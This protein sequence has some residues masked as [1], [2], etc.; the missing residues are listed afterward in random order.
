MGVFEQSAFISFYRHAHHWLWYPPTPAGSPGLHCPD[1]LVR[2]G[3]T[4]VYLSSQPLFH[5]IDMHTTGCGILQP[6]QALLACT[7]LTSL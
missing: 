7:A 5:F 6:Q 2:E 4:W 1:L 3:C